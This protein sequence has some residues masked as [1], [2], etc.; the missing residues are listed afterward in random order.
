MACFVE[1]QQLDAQPSHEAP[2]CLMQSRL[3]SGFGL[4]FI[5]FVTSLIVF[6]ALDAMATREIPLQVEQF[7]QS[8][9]SDSEA[10][11]AAVQEA[12]KRERNAWWIHDREPVLI[13]DTQRAYRLDSLAYDTFDLK[14]IPDKRDRL[15]ARILFNPEPAWH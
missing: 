5:W 15:T 6:A 2:E 10:I 12:R 11:A 3:F 4:A 13:F 7:R 1:N 9:M 8:G 14:I